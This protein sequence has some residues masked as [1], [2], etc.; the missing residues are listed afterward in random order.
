MSQKNNQGNNQN[1]KP[2][3]R[4]ATSS[5]KCEKRGLYERHTEK[6]TSSKPGSN[7]PPKK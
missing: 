3:K 5:G 2:T 4:P 1:R 7:P 6:T